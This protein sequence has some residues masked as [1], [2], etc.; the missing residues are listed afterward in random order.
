[1]CFFFL[2]HSSF[3]RPDFV[4]YVRFAEYI[5]EAVTT[6]KLERLPRFTPLQHIPSESSKKT[7]LNFDERLSMS[8][9]MDKLS[10]VREPNLEDI[11]KVSCI[12]DNVNDHS[13]NELSGF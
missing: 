1:M 6:G 4:E 10:A 11:F 2:F 8:Q 13:I 7:F 12:A 3:D 9:A 5:E